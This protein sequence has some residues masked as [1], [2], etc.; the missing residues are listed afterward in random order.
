MKVGDLVKTLSGDL[1]IILKHAGMDDHE[2]EKSWW[3][4]SCSSGTTWY[5]EGVLEVVNE[6][7]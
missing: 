7:R 5:F 2:Q 4:V 3:V 1:G 6:S